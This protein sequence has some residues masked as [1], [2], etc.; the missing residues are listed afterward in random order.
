[1]VQ[2]KS[3]IRWVEAIGTFMGK[4]KDISYDP[5]L[6]LRRGF[7]VLSNE[8]HCRRWYAGIPFIRYAIDPVQDKS[9]WMPETFDILPSVEHNYQNK[10]YASSKEYIMKILESYSHPDNIVIRYPT[11]FDAM[12]IRR[13]LI[14][15]H[16]PVKAFVIEPNESTENMIYTKIF[17]HAGGSFLMMPIIEQDGFSDIFSDGEES[18]EIVDTE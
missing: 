3:V 1:M 6:A 7:N 17:G 13:F 18:I 8:L 10:N 2:N 9:F 15:N 5:E 16:M 11:Q 4:H 12:K 14:A